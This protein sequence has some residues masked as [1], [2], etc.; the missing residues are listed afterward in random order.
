[1][2]HLLFTVGYMDTALHPNTTFPA[3]PSGVSA[4]RT[5]LVTGQLALLLLASLGAL[6]SFELLL[7]VTPMD[8]E[9][10]GAGSSEA[11][12]VTASLM[13]A[14]VLAE[15]A[16]ARL[17]GRYGDRL[18]FAA[19]AMLL[20]GPALALL[21]PHAVALIVAVS[22]ARGIGFGLNT[23]VIG[24]LV[25]TAVPAERRGEGIGMVG[26]VDCIPAIVAL[27]S[28]VWLAEHAG[29]AVVIVITAACG[30]AP[31]AVVPWLGSATK[32]GQPAR[33]ADAADLDPA[34]PAGLLA[35]LRSP[36]QRRPA[37]VFAATTVSAGVV[38]SFLPLA[39]GV[40]GGVAALGLL[41][42]GV[43]ST[44]G[45]WWAGRYGDQH[46][47]AGLLVPGLLT[48][49]AGM[50]MLI[51]MASPTALIAGMCLFGTGFGVC[52]NVTFA[53]MIDR[54][55]AADYGTTS[56]LW[57]LAYDG[58]YGAGP[59]GF[60]TFVGYTGYPA[61]FA[62]TG[63]LMLGALLPA[64]RDRGSQSSPPSGC[65]GRFPARDADDDVVRGRRDLCG[66]GCD[67]D[68]LADRARQPVADLA[69]V[70]DAP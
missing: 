51:W 28:G 33:H 39:T 20:G 22:I 34:P 31:L 42:Q 18:V 43:A 36:G 17:I 60:G 32:R 62:L 52:Q 9:S 10:S 38:A 1:M 26:V 37:L 57:N 56:A 19:G 8:A 63:A 29:Y 5:R 48:A 25:A 53:V 6:T 21:A 46:G 44:A 11:G 35:S 59:A 47:H 69:H 55:P 4:P 30:L 3:G 23:V 27:P 68:R 66:T 64:L 40:S 13:L 2:F 7:S 49:A 61:A 41:V 54:A 50:V 70:A 58:G 65:R 24:A 12:L 16:S 67:R 14:T 15:L 45:R